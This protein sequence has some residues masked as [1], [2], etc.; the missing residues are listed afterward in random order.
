MKI[1]PYYK[2]KSIVQSRN[3]DILI[4]EMFDKYKKK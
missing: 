4:N 1:L 2:N 3:M